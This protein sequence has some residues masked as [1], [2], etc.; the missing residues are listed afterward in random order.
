MLILWGVLVGVFAS[1]VLLPPGRPAA[2]G[3]AVAVL[4][5][6]ALWLTRGEDYVTPI[7]VLSGTGIVLA[8]LAQAVRWAFGGRMGRVTTYLLFAFGLLLSAVA[9]GLYG[10]VR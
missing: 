7:V 4:A 10:L 3:I 9:L 2:L 8:A 5:V 1:L 6:A